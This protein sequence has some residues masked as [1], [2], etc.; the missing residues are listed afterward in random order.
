METTDLK[1]IPFN[2]IKEYA[3][4]R[5][6]KIIEANEDFQK[7]KPFL[8]V[9]KERYEQLALIPNNTVKERCLTEF[10]QL[11]IKYNGLEIKHFFPVLRKL[12]M[13]YGETN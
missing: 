10:L 2:K 6:K 7:V 13:Y 1:S 5:T 9:H 3:D 11:I 12:K 4:K 8:A